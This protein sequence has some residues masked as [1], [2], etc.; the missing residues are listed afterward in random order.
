M[1][2][3]D[4]EMSSSNEL[5]L[6]EQEKEAQ[7]E[8]IPQERQT[9]TASEPNLNTLATQKSSTL[10]G[11]PSLEYSLN[12]RWF[13]IIFFW[14]LVIIDSVVMP[15]A[16]YFGLWYGTNLSP[17][18]VFSIVT[19]ALGGVSIIEYFLRFWRLWKKNSRCRVIGGRRKY[20]SL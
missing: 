17:N 14:Q 15:I 6:S 10:P 5:N 1:A 18:T 9:E 2:E 12:G 16:L 8:D 4:P 3:P 20:V 11:P 7:N 13:W 19:A